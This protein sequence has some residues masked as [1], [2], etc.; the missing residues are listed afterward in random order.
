MLPNIALLAIGI[1]SVSAY[2]H[3]AGTES[4]I[5]HRYADNDDAAV[6]ASKAIA[7]TSDGTPHSEYKEGKVFDRWVQIWLEGYGEFDKASADPNLAWLASQGITLTNYFGVAHPSQPNYVAAAGGDTFG[8][9]ADFF[10][11]IADNTSSVTDILE[12]KGMTR[13]SYK[14]CS[15][16]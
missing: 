5:P 10:E 8:F 6:D 12:D 3:N 7:P 16:H 4:N 15:S 2:P 14:K 11:Q 9:D 13:S 1:A